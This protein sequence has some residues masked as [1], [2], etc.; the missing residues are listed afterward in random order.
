[1]RPKNPSEAKHGDPVVLLTGASGL[2]WWR[3]FHSSALKS[4]MR[5]LQHE[6][7]RQGDVFA[8]CS[9]DEALRK[10]HVAY[11]LSSTR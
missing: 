11:Y 7:C 9:L 5:L 2:R 3:C 8:A 6:R 10:D 1:M 4:S